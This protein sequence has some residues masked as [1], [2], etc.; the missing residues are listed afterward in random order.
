ML[1]SEW[2]APPAG[3]EGDAHPA[4]PGGPACLDPRW[5]HAPHDDAAPLYATDDFRI[6][7][8]KVCVWRAQGHRRSLLSSLENGSETEGGWRTRCAAGRGIHQHAPVP[9]TQKKKKFR[10]PRAPRPTPTTLRPARLRTQV[11]VACAPHHRPRLFEMGWVQDDGGASVC[12][13]RRGGPPGTRARAASSPLINSLPKIP[14]HARTHAGEKAL[15]RD[16]RSAIYTGI[17][18]PDMKKVRH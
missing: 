16:P 8:F 9:N 1:A 6:Y 18:C 10:S 3:A 4:A 12:A 7:G 14:T 17:A 2:A 11:R 13:C 15:R 5:P